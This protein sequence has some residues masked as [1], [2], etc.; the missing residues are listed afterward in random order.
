MRYDAA[1]RNTVARYATADVEIGGPVV[2]RGEKLF[3]GLH[4][5][6]H[7]PAVFDQP[8]ELDLGRAPNRHIGF[9]IGPHFC[10]GAGLARMA[11]QIALH[12]TPGSLPVDRARRRGRVEAVVHHPGLESLPLELRHDVGRRGH[13][14]RRV[15]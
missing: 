3:V 13:G 6:N 9:N 10:L 2:R 8:L 12:A 7:D 15:P 1:T 4:P 14:R 11:L 5:V